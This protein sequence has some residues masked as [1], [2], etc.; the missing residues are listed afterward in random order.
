M[1]PQSHLADASRSSDVHDPRSTSASRR[2]SVSVPVDLSAVLTD[3]SATVGRLRGLQQRQVEDDALHTQLDRVAA[4]LE[5]LITR[6]LHSDGVGSAPAPVP[7][8]SASTPRRRAV[9]QACLDWLAEPTSA[10]ELV[11]AGDEEGVPLSGVL[12]ELRR[13]GRPLPAETAASIGLPVGTTVGH[14]AVELLAVRDP[15]GPRCRS[16]RAA[17]YYL[18]DLD[19]GR[20]SA[21]TDARL[22]R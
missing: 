1:Q 8:S 5:S 10:D 20:S 7:W 19:R 18:R 4:D 14:A 11:V 6:L 12:G 17:V 2:R 21:T 9:E 13:S 22:C 15:A 3:L 16:F